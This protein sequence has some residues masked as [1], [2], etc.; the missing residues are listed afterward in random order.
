MISLIDTLIVLESLKKFFLDLLEAERP[1]WLLWLPIGV[2]GGVGLYFSCKAEPSLWWMGLPILLGMLAFRWAWLWPGAVVALGFGV[3][4][5]KASL[6]ATPQLD[7]ETPPFVFQGTLEKVERRP[8]DVRLTLGSLKY[9]HGGQLP[10]QRV[11]LSC[12]GNLC[13]RQPLHPGQLIQVKAVLLP[14]QSSAHP[15]GYDF[16]R[17]AYFDGLGAVGYIIAP[18]C[19]LQGG[20]AT[21]S[22]RLSYLRDGL[23]QFL[24]AHL[25]GLAGD[26]AAALVTGDRSG[27]P[28]AMRQLFADA[29][30]AHVLAI[31]GLHL[32][33]VAGFFFFLVRTLLALIPP[34]A[35]RWDT[36]KIAAICAFVGISGYLALCGASLP[37]TRAYIMTILVLGGILLDRSALSLRNVAIAATVL[38]LFMPEAL[39]SPSFQLSFAAVIALIAGY[40]RYYSTFQA[41]MGSKPSWGRKLFLYGMGIVLSTLLST[42]ATTPYAIY[43]FHRFTLHAIPANMIII[44]LV[45]F[46]IMPG[47]VLFLLMW[48]LSCL[49]GLDQILAHSLSFMVAVSQE[50]STWHGSNIP[51]K[52]MPT[53]V[54]V[55]LTFGLLVFF[56]VKHPLRHASFLIIG[57]A[58]VSWW[59]Q[60]LPNV[61]ISKSGELVGLYTPRGLE[62]NTLQKDKFARKSWMSYCGYASVR[63]NPYLL[64]AE[65]M[66]FKKILQQTIALS[67]QA[68]YVWVSDG[69]FK[70][71]TVQDT[72]GHR[73]WSKPAA[74]LSIDP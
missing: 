37:A 68:T 14:P 31:S 30:V 61:F 7:A 46:I 52:A 39:I 11:R 43:T 20:I 58:L 19:S 44:P 53:E 9:K 55:A 18:P 26:I 71:L 54:L 24:R 35:L 4:L 49:L 23:T 17:Q 10:L 60:P 34:L 57:G 56:L 36:K 16:R 72:I 27:I 50:I 51:V 42:I 25:K 5:G 22:H 8:R 40:E 13:Q 41:W 66:L 67:G 6:L 12:R 47:L 74:K 59:Y 62:V 33:L 69:N 1:R 45:S 70:Y 29:G 2:G 38:L 63:K 32:S 15:Y 48:P 21:S 73:P 28:D 3:A 65:P 64:H